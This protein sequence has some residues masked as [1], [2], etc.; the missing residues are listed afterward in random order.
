MA[1]VVALDQREE[2]VVSDRRH[3]EVRHALQRRL[4]VER[5][6]QQIPGLREEAQALVGAQLGLVERRRDALL[7]DQPRRDLLGLEPR[8]ALGAVGAGVVDHQRRALRELLEEGEVFVGDRSP[9]HADL[10]QPHDL[11]AGHHRREQGVIGGDLFHHR[12]VR[13]VVGELPQHRAIGAH[14][15]HRLPGA[16]HLEERVGSRRVRGIEAADLAQDARLLRAPVGDRHLAQGAVLHRLDRAVI[17]DVTDQE[18]G[19]AIERLVARQRRGQDRRP[20]REQH[21]APL[22]PQRHRPRALQP[23]AEAERAHVLWPAPSGPAP[24]VQ[25]VVRGASRIQHASQLRRT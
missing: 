11:P 24:L 14:P 2:A 6:R 12:E 20:L 3:R 25:I 13:V 9:V 8:L 18:P 4:V 17:G 15:A 21:Q 22:R 19:D 7:P 5:E 16:Q 10:H 1:D 23:E